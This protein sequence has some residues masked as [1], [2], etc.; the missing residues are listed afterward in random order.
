MREAAE[1]ASP[2]VRSIAQICE[3]VVITSSLVRRLASRIQVKSAL[4]A[5]V[6]FYRKAAGQIKRPR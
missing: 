5:A 2:A 6:R 3:R 4:T 1:P